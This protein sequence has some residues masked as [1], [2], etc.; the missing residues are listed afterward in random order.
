MFLRIKHINKRHFTLSDMLRIKCATP[1]CDNMIEIQKK[2]K[3]KK[4]CSPA[5]NRRHIYLKKVGRKTT[6]QYT[7][8]CEYCGKKIDSKKK[9]RFCSKS[10]NNKSYRERNIERLRKKERKPKKEITCQNPKCN[11]KIL[12]TGHQKYCSDRCRANAQYWREV[13][14]RNKYKLP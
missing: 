9:K 14:Q 11:K 12:T 2:G 6:K 8:K 4:Y 5:C 7:G 13:K 10:C 1:D 3:L